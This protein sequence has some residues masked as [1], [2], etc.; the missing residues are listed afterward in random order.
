MDGTELSARVRAALA[1]LGVREVRMFGGI[2]FMLDGNMVAAAST[3]G[4]L[5]RV[6]R[7]AIEALLARPG[8]GVMEMRGRV[9]ADY[10]RVEPDAVTDANV[11]EWLGPAVAFVRSL[12]AKAPAADGVSRAKPAQKRKTGSPKR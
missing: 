10:L 8:A 11:A 4:L 1:G 9:M 7:D 3:R 2:G 12:P 6:G 5:L